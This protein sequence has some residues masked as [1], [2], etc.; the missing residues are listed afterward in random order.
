MLILCFK[1]RT[2]GSSYACPRGGR[3]RIPQRLGPKE[4]ISAQTELL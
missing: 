4:Y 2:V 3:P 1:K